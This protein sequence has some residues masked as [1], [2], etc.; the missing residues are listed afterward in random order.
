[1][2][3]ELKIFWEISADRGIKG[4]V[5]QTLGKEPTEQMIID[6]AIDYECINFPIKIEKF[7]IFG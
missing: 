3:K 4:K 1:M 6:F 2:K 5:V 7:A